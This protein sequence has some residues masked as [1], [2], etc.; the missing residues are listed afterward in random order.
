MRPRVVVPW[1][2][3]PE[4]VE[5]FAAFTARATGV[6]VLDPETDVEAVLPI[7][8]RDGW[9]VVPQP[10]PFSYAS[11]CNAGIGI[12][13]NSERPIVVLNSDVVGPPEVMD[14]ISAEVEGGRLY[15]PSMMA[16]SAFGVSVPYIEGWCVAATADTWRVLGMF[17]AEYAGAFWE[18]TDLGLKALQ[19]GV[20]LVKRPWPVRH[21]GGHTAS[22]VI[23]AFDHAPDNEA[24]WRRKACRWV[25][26]AQ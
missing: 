20:V 9:S 10:R 13:T 17:D 5:G 8:D 16:Q 21:L 26:G 2:G 7:W 24:R 22:S 23:G 15:G 11:A 25:D 6:I 3:A 12:P 19:R 18:D 14:M 4:L 1:R